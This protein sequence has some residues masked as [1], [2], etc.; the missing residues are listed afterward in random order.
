MSYTEFEFQVASD[1][2]LVRLIFLI[3]EDSDGPATFFHD[4]IS[5]LGKTD[6]ANG[7]AIAG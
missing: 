2:G 7:S 1:A 4:P 3:G 5:G 6:F